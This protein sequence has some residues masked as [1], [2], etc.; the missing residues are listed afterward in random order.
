MINKTNL[1]NGFQFQWKKRAHRINKIALFS[2]NNQINYTFQ[3]GSWTKKNKGLRS[4]QCNFCYHYIPIQTKD[5]KFIEKKTRKKFIFE[6]G[7]GKAT[8]T[9]NLN[10]LNIKNPKKVVVFLRGFEL[11]TLPPYKF[12]MTLRGLG[13][14]IEPPKIEKNK[15]TF[16]YGMQFQGK[17]PRRMFGSTKKD[18]RKVK[19]GY[20]C[21][22]KLHYTIAIVKKGN[23]ALLNEEGKYEGRPKFLYDFEY[24]LE[25]PLKDQIVE[26]QGK[27][28]YPNS[29]V[30]LTGFELRW[31]HRWGL[32][33]SEIDFFNHDFKYDK[34]TGKMKFK[35]YGKI[36]N[37]RH[38]PFRQ[39]PLTQI[40][41]S[42]AMIQLKDT[43]NTK[44]EKKEC[45]T[46][47]GE[48]GK[49]KL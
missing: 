33:L 25:P 20:K 5:I 42:Y 22:G 24:K 16:N 40:Y 39:K 11:E 10:S 48:L 18:S 1:M 37:A 26:I 34:K 19:D 9:I 44:K 21:K 14:W 38:P 31:F 17:R 3:G 7:E 13:V 6:N 12:G 43:T 35:T 8:E 49:A 29:I 41:A 4:D 30:G 36:V 32:Y 45:F 47:S 2:K 46:K 15:L 28:S 23:I 27:K